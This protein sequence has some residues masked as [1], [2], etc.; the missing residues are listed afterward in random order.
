VGANVA[1]KPNAIEDE[2]RHVPAHGGADV[3]FLPLDDA[4]LSRSL[5][6]VVARRVAFLTEYQNAAYAKRYS[7]WSR[8]CVPPKRSVRRA[9]ATWAR[10]WRVTRSS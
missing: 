2:L 6:E 5:D 10:P 3:A 9:A 8:R 7:I 4:R 1:P